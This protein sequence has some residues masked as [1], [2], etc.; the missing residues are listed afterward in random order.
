MYCCRLEQAKT[1]QQLVADDKEDL[2]RQLQDIGR[3]KVDCIYYW[4]VA[5]E[6]YF[7]VNLQISSLS[8][9]RN[10]TRGR[11]YFTQFCQQSSD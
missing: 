1:A 9:L 5:I 2:E 8:S 7:A 4:I 10:L 3:A 11:G 6:D